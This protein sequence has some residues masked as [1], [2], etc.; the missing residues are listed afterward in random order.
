[1]KDHAEFRERAEH[2]VHVLYR[3]L[4][5]AGDDFGFEA[6]LDSGVLTVKFGKPNTRVVVSPHLATHQVW[7]SVAK[8][9]YK[10]GW[11]VVENA[12]VLDE[13]GET[14][15]ELLEQAISRQSGEDVSL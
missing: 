12:F 4:S 14:L 8:K 11:D 13:T 3:A 5:T 6:D 9:V 7:L 1:M 15:K 10:L 2:A